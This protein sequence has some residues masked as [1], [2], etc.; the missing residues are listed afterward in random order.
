[1]QHTFSTSSETGLK[2]NTPTSTET[3]MK[4]DAPSCSE[5]YVEINNTPLSVAEGK[6]TIPP[7]SKREIKSLNLNAKYASKDIRYENTK[8]K[9]P[10][11]HP[12][13]TIG[14]IKKEK[15]KDKFKKKILFTLFTTGAEEPSEDCNPWSSS[16]N[17]YEENSSYE[18]IY[19]V[20]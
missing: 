14:P 11:Q 6:S 1:M 20:I 2:L 5:T 13:S 15:V 12:I 7:S 16:N 17:G 9:K 19:S 4:F 3:E 10:K 8:M 18:I